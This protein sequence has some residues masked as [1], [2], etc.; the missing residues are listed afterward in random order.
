MT[1]PYTEA[2]LLITEAEICKQTMDMHRL[3]IRHLAERR[4]IAII[5]LRGHMSVSQI[6]DRMEISHAAVYQ[7]MRGTR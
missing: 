6:A 5:E 4:R 2:D 7:L 3:E 1:G